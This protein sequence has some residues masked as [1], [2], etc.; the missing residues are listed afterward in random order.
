[1]RRC[2]ARSSALTS[3]EPA[4]LIQPTEAARV[5]HPWS[6]RILIGAGV[7][8]LVAAAVAAGVTLANDPFASLPDDPDVIANVA[9]TLPAE[10]EPALEQPAGIA[11]RGNR[12]YVADSAAGVVR[13]FN[14]YGVDKGSIVLPAPEAASSRPGALALADGGRL[15]I[16]DSG[17]G[18]VVVVKAAAAEEAE[19]LFALGDAA[20][21]TAPIRPVAVSYADDEYF[22]AGSAEA[23]VRVYDRNGEAVRELVLE[24]EPPVEY[25]GGLLVADGAIWLSDTKSGRVLSFDV[26]TGE[27]LSEWPDAYTVPR[28]LATV[29]RGFA[30]A[31]VL[32]QTAYVVGSSGVRTHSI[33]A[34]SVAGLALALPEAV[35]W[36]D[37]RSRLYV[38]DA[39]AGVVIALNVRLE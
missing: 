33:D 36:D 32:G 5:A 28:G 1:M 25:P 10:G 17:R 7:V 14:R 30:V 6:R 11:I 23:V 9:G 37:A 15:A 38:V 2:L 8:L 19:V 16:V 27:L 29:G 39:A 24:A 13:I 22:V 31:D 26:Q 4:G 3:S 34:E 35:A 21:G 20:A 18:Q 12:V